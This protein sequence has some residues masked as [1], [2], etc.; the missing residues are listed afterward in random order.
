MCSFQ[1]AELLALYCAAEIP[2]SGHFNYSVY[3]REALHLISSLNSSPEMKTFFYIS[4]APSSPPRKLTEMPQCLLRCA[5]LI[6]LVGLL[7][8]LFLELLFL[9]PACRVFMPVVSFNIEQLIIPHLFPFNNI[10]FFFFL[11]SP[12]PLS[13]K[14]STFWICLIVSS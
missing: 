10:A 8:E 2:L 14:M 1:A 5:P 9:N 7:Q 4:T 12:G 13:Y 6:K 3:S 11:K